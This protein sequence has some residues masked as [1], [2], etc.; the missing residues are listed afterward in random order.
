M[1]ENLSAKEYKAR[2]I[3]AISFWNRAIETKKVDIQCETPT[4]YYETET[5]EDAVTPRKIRA[6][7]GFDKLDKDGDALYTKTTIY[8]KRGDQTQEKAVSE[9]AIS[10]D[11]KP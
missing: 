2:G 3:E 11:E 1:W 5:E 9:N 7:Y 4:E 6:V 8:S 10:E